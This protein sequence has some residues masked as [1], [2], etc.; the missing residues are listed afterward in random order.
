MLPPSRPTGTIQEA[1]A[2]CGVSRR[3]IYNWIAAGKIEYCRTASG[4]VRVYLDTLYRNA[5]M[6]LG[7]PESEPVR[8]FIV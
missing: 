6:S 8:E 3:T 4:S 7:T 1:C 2:H 5:D